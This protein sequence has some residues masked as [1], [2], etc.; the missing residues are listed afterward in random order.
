MA[1]DDP[2]IELQRK[3]HELFRKKFASGEPITKDE[4]KAITNWKQK[5]LDT[6]WSKQLRSILARRPDGTYR[7]TESFRNFSDFKTFRGLVTQV[8]QS[9][10]ALPGPP[11]APD[12][13]Q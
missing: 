4:V 11:A 10:G 3:G 8:K 9:G 13:T 6:Y 1:K 12:Y 5:T 2:R 7:V